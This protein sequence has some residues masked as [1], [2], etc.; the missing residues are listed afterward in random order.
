MLITTAPAAS[1]KHQ[2]W[3]RLA[4]E[5]FP[6]PLSPSHHTLRT[7]TAHLY[8]T[9]VGTDRPSHTSV[10]L[11]QDSAGRATLRVGASTRDRTW[12]VRLHLPPG[13]IAH[14]A[15][16]DGEVVELAMAGGPSTDETRALIDPTRAA[17]AEVE[18]RAQSGRAHVVTFTLARERQWK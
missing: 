9:K 10:V 3:E 15:G 2:N 14:S 16:I 5:V 11:E 4:L 1:T 12:R 18:L 6:F 8:D 17:T 7:T 13:Y